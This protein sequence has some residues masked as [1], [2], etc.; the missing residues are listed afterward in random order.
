MAK[1]LKLKP[2][3]CTGA[4]DYVVFISKYR[5]EL[6]DYYLFLFPEHSLIETILDKHKMYELAV[7]HNIPCPKTYVIEH[8]GQLEEAILNLGFPCILKP[9]LGHKFRKK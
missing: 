9:T 8:K 1:E 6:S 4:D 3:L 7:K 2:V 5:A